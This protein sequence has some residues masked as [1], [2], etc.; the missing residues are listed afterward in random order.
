MACHAP[1]YKPGDPA[2]KGYLQWNEWAEVQWS[3]G[4]RQVIKRVEE[5]IDKAMG[6]WK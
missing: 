3:A 6:V 2:P 5:A 4:L 1:I